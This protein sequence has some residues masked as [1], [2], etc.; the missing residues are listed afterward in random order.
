MSRSISGERR[1]SRPW[2]SLTFLI[3]GEG[4]LYCAASLWTLPSIPLGGTRISAP[5]DYLCF[6][7]S[8]LKGM[9][10]LRIIGCFSDDCVAL[11]FFPRV[12]AQNMIKE[13]HEGGTKKKKENSNSSSPGC[14]NFSPQLFQFKFMFTRRNTFSHSMCIQTKKIHSSIIYFS[15]MCSCMCSCPS[16]CVVYFVS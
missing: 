6:H 1:A 16:V 2:V 15:A 10:S 14:L 5:T 9:F 3:G 11:F 8:D 12:C 7:C 13:L 4:G